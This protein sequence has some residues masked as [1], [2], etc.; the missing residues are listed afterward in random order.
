MALVKKIFLMVCSILSLA[1]AARAQLDV[2]ELMGMA[3]ELSSE[4][5]MDLTQLREPTPEEW[6]QMWIYF[7]EVMQSGSLADMAEMRPYADMAL[8]YLDQY[9]ES[10][11]LADWLRQ[12]ID[13][14]W[15][16]E[17]VMSEAPPTPAPRPVPPTTTKPTPTPRPAPPTT[18]KPPPHKPLPPPPASAAKKSMD[19]Q[20]WVQRIGSRPAPANAASLVPRLKPIFREHGVPESLVW[21]A[22][23]ESTFDPKAKSPVGALG[24]YQFMPATATRFGLKL[25]PDDERI[26]PEKSATAAAQYLKYLHGKFDSWPLALAAY[27]AGEGRVGKLLK[28]H[29]AGTFEGIAAHLPAETRMYVPKVA[30][31]I[32]VRDGSD[33]LRLP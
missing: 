4:Y 18:I 28:Q 8:E 19:V 23:V 10:K 13:Y 11:P 25:K 17:Q 1:A 5:E 9:E 20:R 24:L 22:E 2:E 26:I 27:N 32:K 21:L 12:R 7:N 29:K 30:A 14:L 33:L 31:V 16:A 6:Q 3:S 15:M